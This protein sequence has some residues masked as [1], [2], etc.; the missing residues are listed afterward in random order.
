MRK[1][2]T[3]T[4]ALEEACAPFFPA[5]FKRQG[6]VGLWKY[7][8]VSMERKIVVEVHGCWWH[9]CPTCHPTGASSSTQF[10]TLENDE[11]KNGFINRIGWTL[12][13]VWG[14]DIEKDPRAALQPLFDALA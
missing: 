14:H 13:I 5:D 12:I 8:F 6:T 10:T 9:C 1:T 11:K 3:K 2:N 7:D 4:L